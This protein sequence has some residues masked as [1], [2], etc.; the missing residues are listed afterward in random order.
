MAEVIWTIPS[1]HDLETILEC[2]ELDDKV[3]A[4]RLARKV[5]E[6]T[7][8]LTN[9]PNSGSKLEKYGKHTIPQASLGNDIN[10]SPFG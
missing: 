4:K 8:R 7:D 5:F 2:L 1:L 9:F 6:K 3:A 10:L